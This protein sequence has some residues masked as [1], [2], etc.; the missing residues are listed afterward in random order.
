MLRKCYRRGGLR[1][2]ERCILTGNSK[3]GKLAPASR[4][5]SNIGA[6]DCRRTFPNCTVEGRKSRPDDPDPDIYRYSADKI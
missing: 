1:A 2:L 5:I 6:Y 4:K 3:S